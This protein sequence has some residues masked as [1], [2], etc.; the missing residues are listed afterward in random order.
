MKI[1]IRILFLDIDG[2]LNSTDSQKK[3]VDNVT[4]KYGKSW[5]EMPDYYSYRALNADKRHI[6]N[7][8]SILNASSAQIVISSSWRDDFTLWAWNMMMAAW[9]VNGKVIGVTNHNSS[10]GDEIKDW[11]HEAHHDHGLDTLNIHGICILDDDND[12]GDLMPY[13]VNIDTNKGLTK[14]DAIKAIYTLFGEYQ[15]K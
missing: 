1:P 7:L 6:N 12:M 2:V 5:T 11:L 10:R 9:G 4:K 14:Q 15:W 8:N 13:L 3:F